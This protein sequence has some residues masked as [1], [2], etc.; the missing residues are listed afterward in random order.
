MLEGL[1]SAESE[2]IAEAY[3]ADGLFLSTAEDLVELCDSGGS[4]TAYASAM[5]DVGME[6]HIYAVSSIACPS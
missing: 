1:V 5:A 6:D 4:L 3:K 2:S